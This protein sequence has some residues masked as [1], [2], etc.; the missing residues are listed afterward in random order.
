LLNAILSEKVEDWKNLVV[1]AGYSLWDIVSYAT[2]YVFN[3]MS[4]KSDEEIG[5]E[6]KRRLLETAQR[7]YPLLKMDEGYTVFRPLI[8]V[9]TNDIVQ[10]IEKIGIPILSTPCKFQEFRPKR[11]LMKYYEKMDMYFDYER[12]LHFAQKLPDF[13]EI[14]SYAAMDKQKYFSNVF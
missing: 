9:N 5:A 8:K 11:H 6:Y 2:E 4:V 13:P 14:K 7:F 1:I 3:Y 10:Q 12:T